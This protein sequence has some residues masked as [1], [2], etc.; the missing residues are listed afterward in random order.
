MDPAQFKPRQ[1]LALN[2]KAL[3]DSGIGP[4][5]QT[6]LATK[7]GVAQATIGRVLAAESSTTIDTVDGI[8]AAYGLQGWQLLVAGMD[9]KNPPVLQPISAAERTLY[10]NLKNAALQ[11]AEREAPT[12]KGK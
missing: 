8:A 12:Y 6:E 9:P 4:T 1:A 5:T 10:E 11:L 3:L 2:V 7:S